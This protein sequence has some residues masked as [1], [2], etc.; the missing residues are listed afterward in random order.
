MSAKSLWFIPLIFGTLIGLS[1]CGDGNR[2]GSKSSRTGS[3]T[4]DSDSGQPP[5]VGRWHLREQPKSDP[6]LSAEQQAKIRE[7]ESIGYVGGSVEPATDKVVTV[8]DEQ[9]TWTGLNFYTSGHA[10]E[11]LLMDMDGNTLHRWHCSYNDAWPDQPL[12]HNSIGK[13]NYWRR[14]YLC[15][16]GNLF[17]IFEGLGLVKLDRNSQII[18]AVRNGAHHD[19]DVMPDGRLYVLTRT[20]HVVPRVHPQSPILEDFVVILDADGHELQRVSVL[21]CFENAG[22]PLQNLA[23]PT[24]H[25]V[26]SKR[27]VV[28]DIFHTN[29]LE[30]LDGRLAGKLPSFKKG[31]VLVSMRTLD[32]I[33]V[34]DLEQKKVVWSLRQDFKAQHD[35]KILPNGNLML[36]DNQGTSGE[37][38]VREFDPLSEET[39]WEYRGSDDHPFYSATC[40]GAQRL[41]NGNTL[42]TESDRGRA[43]EVTQEKE[44]VWEFHNPHRAGDNDQYIAALFEVVRLPPDFPIGWTSTVAR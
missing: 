41:P 25:I 7:L 26:N 6:G 21:E 19:I 31:N 37:S 33:A 8:Y 34:L 30:V 23:I 20:A 5:A 28:P 39:R 13:M 4:G 22:V 14:A 11:A 15:E 44:I 16:N 42:I 24:E 35:P 1:G 36:F 17:V 2:S 43:F 18:W 38:S 32:Q 3:E 12:A 29:T 9:R 40:G 27:A 10:P